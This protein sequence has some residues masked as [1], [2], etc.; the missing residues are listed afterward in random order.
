M[1][2]IKT[3]ICWWERS[4]RVVQPLSKARKNEWNSLVEE[5]PISSP[6]KCLRNAWAKHH[7]MNENLYFSGNV[8]TVSHCFSKHVLFTFLANSLCFWFLTSMKAVTDMSLG[9]FGSCSLFYAGML[10]L[11]NIFWSYI[12]NF[13]CRMMLRGI[14]DS[15]IKIHL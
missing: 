3:P 1:A 8:F 15:W 7:Y 6:S 11:L 4:A 2:K 13:R 12:A 14:G 9:C 5:K 10:T